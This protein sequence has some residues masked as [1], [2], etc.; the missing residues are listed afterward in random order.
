MNVL[1]SVVNKV[2]FAH[3]GGVCV[4]ISDQKVPAQDEKCIVAV[5]CNICVYVNQYQVCNLRPRTS[6]IS[7]DFLLIL[8]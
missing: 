1:N 2:T 3:V 7:G 5:S 6:F 8:I 4:F